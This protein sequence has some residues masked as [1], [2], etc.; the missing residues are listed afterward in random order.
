MN[1]TFRRL[2]TAL[3][4]LVAEDRPDYKRRTRR[5]AAA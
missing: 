3:S 4:D 2:R 5:A 1:S